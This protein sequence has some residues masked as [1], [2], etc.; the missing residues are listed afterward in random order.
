MVKTN[1][2]KTLGLKFSLIVL[3]CWLLINSKFLSINHI[4]YKIFQQHPEGKFFPSSEFTQRIT[5]TDIR[6]TQTESTNSS[7]KLVMLWG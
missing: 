7:P 3:A 5:Q 4:T 6:Q 2:N 1:N